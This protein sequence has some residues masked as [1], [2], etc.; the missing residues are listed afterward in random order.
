MQMNLFFMLH[1]I[2][3]EGEIIDY[4]SYFLNAMIELVRYNNAYDYLIG[5]V[6]KMLNGSLGTSEGRYDKTYE[7]YLIGCFETVIYRG[8][9]CRRFFLMAKD[10]L[11]TYN[12]KYYE[13]QDYGVEALRAIVKR[14]LHDLQ[15]SSIYEQNSYRKI[16]QNCIDAMMFYPEAEFKPDRRYIVFRNCVLDTET[17][18]VYDFDMRFRTNLVL[19]FDYQK[20]KIS[21]LWEKVLAQT[22]PSVDGQMAFQ[23][24]CGAFLLDREKYSF[25]YMCYLVG[26]GRNGK[27]VVSGAVATMLG[28]KLVSNFSPQ[29]LFKDRDM[30]YNRACL[31]GKVANFSDDVT[32]SDFSGGILKQAISGHKMAA[33][34][35]GGRSFDLTEIPLFCCCVNEIPPSSDNSPGQNRRT[36]AITCPNRV[37]DEDVDY[38]LPAKLATK[39]AKIG[40]FNWLLTGY[41]RLIENHGKLRLG[42][43]VRE[44]QHMAVVM[45]SNVHA[46]IEDCNIHRA[47][48]TPSYDDPN[49]RSVSEWYDLYCAWCKQVGE[50]PKRS[51]SMSNIFGDMALPSHRDSSKVYYHALMGAN[52]EETIADANIIVGAGLKADANDTATDIVKRAANQS[53][54]AADTPIPVNPPKLPF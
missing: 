37:A 23:E 44:A 3:F 14:V 19:D 18:Q 4:T 17:R 42:D 21:P 15:I 28:D 27:S 12:G 26:R 8:S 41:Y 11:Y 31:V 35:P 13:T 7:S 46:W 49:W 20:N 2:I 38:E 48:K 40:I 43:S 47:T 45:A 52:A 5:E 22:I 10:R 53:R 51:R 50:K 32:A 29:E 1:N 36:L 25:E 9:K 39:E 16:A 33:R 54:E 24:F 34:H 6:S 30:K